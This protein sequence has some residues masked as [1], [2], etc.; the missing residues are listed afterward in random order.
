MTDVSGGRD[1]RQT[2]FGRGGR[3]GRQTIFGR[4]RRAVVAFKGSLCL[5]ALGLATLGVATAAL[6]AGC[7]SQGNNAAGGTTPSAGAP[8]T[9][10]DDAGKQVTLARPATRIVSLAPAD[11][12]IAYAIGAG[13]KMVGGTSYDDY[14]AQA[15]ALP[16][17]GDFASPSVEKIVALKPDLVLAAGGIQAILRTRLEK[18]GMQVYIVDPTTYAGTIDD[19]GKL[20]ALAGVADQAAKVAQSMRDAL[21]TVQDKIAGLPA[22]SVFFEVYPKPLMTAG[23]GTFIDDLITLAGGRNIASGAGTG[24][25]NFASEVLFKDNPEVY[26]APIGSQSNPGQISS[27][28]GYDQLKAV[29]DKRVFTI[30]DDLVVRPGP[31]LALGLQELARMFHPEASAGP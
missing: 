12:E 30:Q 3:D 24:F 16:K 15:K 11:T 2:T 5:A 4:C 17:V 20:G 22:P 25:I 19:L 23:K 13:S 31:R 28:P 26:V 9:V 27:R 18:L 21:K 8:I 6:L 7:G 29:H 1:G 14:P 10:T